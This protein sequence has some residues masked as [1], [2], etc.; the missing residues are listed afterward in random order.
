MAPWPTFWH[1]SAWSYL[2]AGRTLLQ[3]TDAFRTWGR[4][5]NSRNTRHFILGGREAEEGIGVFWVTWLKSSMSWISWM[6][7]AFCQNVNFV[8]TEN[9]F[10]NGR[11]DPTI[12][13]NHKMKYG[14]FKRGRRSDLLGLWV[15]FKVLM[16]GTTIKVEANL[17][18]WNLYGS[19]SQSSL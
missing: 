9:G 3:M 5:F 14:H 18:Y 2:D 4:S 12:E 16:V 19:I 6:L 11:I 7:T 10:L 17:K 13:L 8:K 15:S 1:P